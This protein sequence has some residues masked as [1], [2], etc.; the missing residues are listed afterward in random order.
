MLEEKANPYKPEKS[1][2]KLQP[3]KDFTHLHALF[4]SDITSKILVQLL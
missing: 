3:H 2:S 1:G 4:Q